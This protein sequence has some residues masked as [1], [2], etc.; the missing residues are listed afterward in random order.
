MIQPIKECL[1]Q[2]IIMAKAWSLSG[3]L[4]ARACS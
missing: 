4:K 2:L 3:F 1:L